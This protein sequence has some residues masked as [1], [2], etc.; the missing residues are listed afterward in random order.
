M[1]KFL[2]KN[3]YQQVELH[4]CSHCEKEEHKLK[5]CEECGKRLICKSCYKEEDLIL[6]KKCD[7][8]YKLWVNNGLKQIKEEE[9]KI[10]YGYNDDSYAGSLLNDYY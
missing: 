2:C 5:K 3:K 4:Q 1:F 9:K 7:D 10:K 6:C 8:E